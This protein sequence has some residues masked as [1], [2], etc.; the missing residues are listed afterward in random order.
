VSG[1]V[2]REGE[3]HTAL[4]HRTQR[5]ADRTYVFTAVSTKLLG[6]I[7]LGKLEHLVDPLA[8]PV[9]TAYVEIVTSLAGVPQVE[10]AIGQAN[11]A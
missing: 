6:R 3:S 4:T 7:E 2:V 1:E 5:S 11:P 9:L 10:L 8:A